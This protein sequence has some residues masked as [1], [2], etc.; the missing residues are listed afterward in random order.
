MPAMI[1]AFSLTRRGFI[2]TAAGLASGCATARE[3]IGPP[4]TNARKQ[5][6][7][8]LAASE[9]ED[10]LIGFQPD[11]PFDIP[12]IDLTKLSRRFR[13]T[14]EAH[15]GREPPGTIIIDLDTK[16]ARLVLRNGSAIRYGVAVGEDGKG[17]TGPAAVGR[18]A[19]W[20]S[21]TPTARMRVEDPSL[22]A[23]M[24]GGV[25]NP[26]GARALYV[27]QRGHETLYRLHGTDEPWTIGEED[28]NGCI[29]FLNEDILDLYG[30]VPTG[31]PIIVRRNGQ[32]V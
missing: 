6:A 4:P 28:S 12:L 5:A 29:R 10:W 20:P 18:K 26:M 27:T 14:E 7:R 32:P 31:A 22:P 13:R 9:L 16:H 3:L 24:P 11:E 8:E 23:F 1:D 15:E 25:T 19:I 30:R 21:W 2:L 17:W